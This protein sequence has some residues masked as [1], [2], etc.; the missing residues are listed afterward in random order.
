MKADKCGKRSSVKVAFVV[1]RDTGEG[2]QEGMCPSCLFKGARGSKV[3]FYTC[4]YSI[5]ATAFQS[6]NTTEGISCSKLTE[7]HLIAL[8]PHQYK[9]ST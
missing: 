5:L 8:L 1:D 6:E 7:I 3:P 2:V 9:A 4:F